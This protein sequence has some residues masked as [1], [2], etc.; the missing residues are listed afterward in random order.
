MAHTA[1]AP[2]GC[3]GVQELLRTA[4]AAAASV[5]PYSTSRRRWV[6]TENKSKPQTARREESL[7]SYMRGVLMEA[8]DL[9]DVLQLPSRPALVDAA[10]G[11]HLSL[12]GATALRLFRKTP[13]EG[14]AV[15]RALQTLP[16]AV[17]ATKPTSCDNMCVCLSGKPCFPQHCMDQRCFTTFSSSTSYTTGLSRFCKDLAFDVP[18][19]PP[20]HLFPP[21]KA[22]G[23]QRNPAAEPARKPAAEGRHM[24]P[25]VT[26]VIRSCLLH[27]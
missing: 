25:L 19:H 16:R 13:Q 22:M 20:D 24:E 9:K 15:C 4:S 1:G 23:G 17:L 8:T 18:R 5:S 11:L 2:R 26:S 6:P 3:W 27:S 10:A 7:D 14:R 21:W 12:S